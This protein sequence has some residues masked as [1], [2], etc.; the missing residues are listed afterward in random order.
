MR[1]RSR[2]LAMLAGVALVAALIPTAL[3]SAVPPVTVTDGPLPLTAAPAVAGTACTMTCYVDAATGNDANGGA[4]PG[5]AKKTIQAA[6][7]Q[8]SSGGEVRV[9]PGAYDETA[10]GRGTDT[11]TGPYQFGLFFPPSK[12]GITLQGVTA[13]DVPITT[14]ATIAATVTTNATNSFGYSGVF[15]SA[16]NITIRGM[17]FGANA[18]G[19]E[20][21][22]EVIG[23]GFMLDASKITSDGNLYIADW[24]SRYSE[25]GTPLDFTDDTSHIT[26]YTITGDMF[27]G[28]SSP[29]IANGA[30]VS[31]PV[32]GRV[33]TGNLFISPEP[34]SFAGP[35]SAAW[36]KYPVGGAVFTGNTFTAASATRYIQA[37]G[38]V[39]LTS[40]FDWSD[41]FTLNTY[42]HP[43]VTTTD[44]NLDHLR[45]Y[46]A[47]AFVDIY[48]VGAIIQNR[49]D[50][51][52]PGDTVIAG[53][54]TFAENV[55]L[56]QQ[57]RLTGAGNTTIIQPTVA[58]PAISIAAGGSIANP[59][60][61]STLKTTGAIGGG[62]TGSGL[63]IVAPGSDVTISH[64]TS[65]GNSGHGLAIN[66][67]ASI[68]RLTLDS[69]DFNGNSGDGFRIPT[70]MTGMDG[71]TIS[72]SHFDNNGFAGMEIYGPPSTGAVTNV[73]ITNST[74]SGDANKG[75]YAERLDNA[76]LDG[77][78]VNA[79]G[80]SGGFAAGI[81]L[82]LKKQA[83]TNITIRNSSITNSGTGDTVNGV[84]ITIKARDDGSYSPTTLVGVT[85]TG[86][87]I[88][89][90]QYGLRFGEPGKSNPGPT[91]VHVNRNNISGNVGGNGAIN[92]SLA[93]DDVTCNWWGNGSGPSGVGLGS[94]DSV[95]TGLTFSP[96]L[97]TSDLNGACGLVPPLASFRDVRRPADIT[98]GPDVCGTGYPS[99]NLKGSA[100][101]AGDTWITVYD[102]T[103]ADA[104]VMNTFGNT[105][106]A[107]DVL[108]RAYNNKKGAGLLALFNEGSGKKGLALVIYDNGNT[109][110]LA[111]GT[112]SKAS[113]TFTVLKTASLANR[114]AE[115]NWYRL[116][117]DVVV[118][119]SNVTVTGNV[120]RHATASNPNSAV[121]V[122]VGSL[123]FT[124]PRPAGV[125]ATGE[126]GIV[127]SAAS[128]VEDSSVT[129][130]TLI[131]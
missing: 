9:F 27:D 50:N 23:N 35:G 84:G 81:D 116:T 14:A 123:S 89:G 117:M 66:V 102:T 31:G 52:L 61:I 16:D 64:V 36:L 100:V 92:V 75:I 79:S 119:G 82:N 71:L 32:S 83:F 34:V 118:S 19:D 126:V 2:L 122:S 110:T 53:A 107:A 85:L 127:G 38:T 67:S 130:F 73:A 77:I 15:V 37:W 70:S 72:N 6:I 104:V 12:A 59:L 25:N 26:S 111:L 128:A 41:I 33:I 58:G 11:D 98:V 54:G 95:S 56:G 51:A 60:V 129:N 94:G 8:V 97:L 121:G 88:T 87:T 120:F 17:G 20:K 28:T 18:A 10:S 86:N 43:V 103:P 124:G 115:C 4:S 3:A 68:T 44:G 42:P 76:T 1:F 78:T 29:Y 22:F 65:S 106:S 46:T 101:A 45:P 13:A 57:L 63:S 69:V 112:V 114:I 74:F 109:D 62:N 21:T 90:N 48:R 7:D 105:S 49:V 93:T 24:D 113:G 30:G 5:D 99:I 91:D 39:Q 55:M 125:D 47:G 131:P 96:W 80:T 108:M 40:Q